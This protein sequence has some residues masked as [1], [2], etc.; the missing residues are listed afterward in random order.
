MRVGSILYWLLTDHLGSTAITTKSDSACQAELRYKAFGENRY[1]DTGKQVTPYR[2]TGQRWERGI[3][4]YFYRSRWYDPAL[5]RFVQA[6][7]IVPDPADP[8]SL[9]RYSYV[10]NKP[11]AVH[12]SD[13]ALGVRG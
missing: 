2:F 3:K 6:D 7:T 11:A 1:I 12:G 9:N 8:Q 5:G 4:L 13:R 10:L